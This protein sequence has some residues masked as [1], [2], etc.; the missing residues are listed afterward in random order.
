MTGRWRVSLDR[1]KISV[2]AATFLPILGI[3][4]AR[5]RDGAKPVAFFGKLHRVRE[6]GELPMTEARPTQIRV[7]QDRRTLTIAFADGSAHSFSAEML[8]VLSPSAEV[9]GHSPEQRVTVAGKIDVKI[10]RIEPV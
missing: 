8:R 4:P 9:Q 5:S 6:R 2:I 10:E 7:S 3:S 1:E